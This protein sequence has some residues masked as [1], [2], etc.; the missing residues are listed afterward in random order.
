MKDDCAAQGQRF[1]RSAFCIAVPL[2]HVS[3]KSLQIC[4]VAQTVVLHSKG[5]G[6]SLLVL[7]AMLCAC[8]RCMGNE[9]ATISAG[10]CR[11]NWDWR[12]GDGS[13]E[14]LGLQNCLAGLR[15]VFA[16][17][18][19]HFTRPLT[20]WR[21]LHAHVGRLDGWLLEEVSYTTCSFCR[22]DTSDTWR[23]SHAKCSLGS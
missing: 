4:G 12:V 5:V 17:M 21:V 6:S 16:S 9:V 20:F 11:Y 13:F 23:K 22:L 18:R 14:G 2:G 19:L 10:E 1:V 15:D 7:G 8:W 3:S